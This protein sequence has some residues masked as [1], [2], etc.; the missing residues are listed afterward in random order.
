MQD[1]SMGS[2]TVIESGRENDGLHAEIAPLGARNL[3][4]HMMLYFSIRN[5]FR[6]SIETLQRYTMYSRTDCRDFS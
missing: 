6:G 2:E 3:P 4:G 5:S 1:V